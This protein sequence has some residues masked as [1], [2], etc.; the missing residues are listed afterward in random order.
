V[1]EVFAKKA[2]NLTGLKPPGDQE[3]SCRGANY[4]ALKAGV[5]NHRPIDSR[6]WYNTLARR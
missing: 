4:G 3:V 2:P 5:M 6:L 1:T